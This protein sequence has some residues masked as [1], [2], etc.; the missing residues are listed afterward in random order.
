MPMDASTTPAVPRHTSNSERPEKALAAIG[1]A[2]ARACW[3]ARG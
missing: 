1:L 2:I 3:S